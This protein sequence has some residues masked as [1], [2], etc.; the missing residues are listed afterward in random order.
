MMMHLS[1]ESFLADLRKDIGPTLENSIHD[2]TSKIAID[3]LHKLYNL[4]D[5][6]IIDVGCG[7]GRDC[8]YMQSLG[9]KPLGITVNKKEFENNNFQKIHFCDMHEMYGYQNFD[10]IYASHVLEHSPVPLLVLYYF[11]KS[12]KDSGFVYI[13][14]PSPKPWSIHNQNHYS[15]FEKAMWL[16]LFSKAKFKC[17]EQI[18]M[19]VKCQ[20]ADGYVDDE[21]WG[22]ILEKDV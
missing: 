2:H 4:K 5:K 21:F 12:I 10:G 15:I 18:N 17:V 3:R 8:L 11:N 9:A 19:Q 22:F 7:L 14:V 6:N 1:F 16:E 20:L 13:E